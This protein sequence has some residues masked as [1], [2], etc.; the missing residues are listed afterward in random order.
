MRIQTWIPTISLSFLKKLIKIV[1]IRFG[2]QIWKTTIS[3]SFLEAETARAQKNSNF[4]WFSKFE[5]Q[6]GFPQ[7]L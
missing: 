4:L 3:L 1:E 2:I 5:Y 6:I 7:F